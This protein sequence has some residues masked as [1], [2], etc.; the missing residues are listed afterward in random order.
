MRAIDSLWTRLRRRFF[1]KRLPPA[2]VEADYLRANP[3]VAHAIRKGL[4]R[5]G[6]D[7]WLDSGA[8]E[9]RRL[10]AD[11]DGLPAD[12]DERSYLLANPDVRV[13]VEAGVFPDGAGHWSAVGRKDGRSY[14]KTYEEREAPDQ[15][16]REW[17][18]LVAAEGTRAT[19]ATS[20][21]SP[22]VDDLDGFDATAYARTN[23]A[24]VESIGR[25]PYDLLEHWKR[26]GFIE[27]RTPYGYRPYAGRTLSADFWSKRDGVSFF[28]L[29]DAKSGLGASA[30]N[31]LAALERTGVPVTAYNVVERAGRFE[32]PDWNP[33]QRDK[34]HIF[35]INAD[36]TH[37]LFLSA[38]QEL[39]DDTYNI[40]IWFWELLDF[41]REW[42]SA[43]GAF[44]EI[45]VA[46]EFV[47]HSVASVSPLPVVKM[48]MV[49][50]EP[51]EAERQPRSDFDIPANAFA[52]ACIF[53][54]GSVIARKNPG[55]AIAAF[56][57]AFG[58]QDDVVLLL[59]YHGSHHYPESLATLLQLAK[60]NPKIR[61]Y[62][63]DFT[64]REMQSFVAA[65]DCLVSPHRSEGFGLN[66]AEAMLAEKP[67]IVTGF[68]G[69]MDFTTDENSYLVDYRLS[70]VGDDCGPYPSHSL[71]AE[72]RV[73]DLAAH[74]R[75][76]FVDRAGAATKARVA[77]ADILA[78]HN[79]ETVADAIRRR[80]DGLQ[81]FSSSRRD[82][83][84]WGQGRHARTDFYP[85]E[86]MRF[87]V[88]IL[89]EDIDGRHLHR[90]VR[91][92]LR[93]AYPHWELIVHADG[94]ARANT[95]WYID[96]LRGNDPRIKISIGSSHQGIGAAR[97]EALALSSNAF[98][99]WL[100]NGDELDLA[101]LSEFAVAILRNPDADLLSSDEE[102]IARVAL[103]EMS[104]DEVE[105][106]SSGRLD[107]MVVRR[108]LLLRAAAS[109]DR[110]ARKTVHV[111]KILYHRR[112][113]D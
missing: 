79:V 96:K 30:R 53:D 57:A 25:D 2:F 85:A 102:R 76:V 71:W 93:Q 8:L 97:R 5:S 60:S 73:D 31:Y 95:R 29:L 28:G 41:R 35:H 101:A 70:E 50:A 54:V 107:P 91:S 69:N 26:R 80:L 87:S 68:S 75:A 66:I 21:G 100:G 88:I 63:R 104:D 74:M 65:I 43:F 81:L 1:R 7:H 111:R 33:D 99:V 36:M 32:V 13:A 62:E 55:A 84:T 94:C 98:V 4:V 86:S 37:R 16:D 105:A 12:F 18:A 106:G 110:A 47:R 15:P 67:V 27:G 6:A 49:V 109:E 48:P 51:V 39:Q 58:E 59:K 103:P 46:S 108:S 82:V 22:G 52:F 61:V 9:G 89:V 113:R 44:D 64:A 40:A 56:D 19:P 77:R 11:D 72:P 20:R 42:M 10:S 38:P 17:D 78:K 45:W 90:S 112:K 23:P 24:V 3:D 92:V 83:E 14:T 34:V